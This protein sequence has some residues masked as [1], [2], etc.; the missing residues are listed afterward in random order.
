MAELNRSIPQVNDPEL[1]AAVSRLLAI[2][3]PLGRL[4]VSD[5]VVPTINLGDVVTPVIEVRQPSFAP[6]EQFG[7]NN[8]LGPAANTIL[9]DTGQL[10]AGVYDVKLI[11]ASDEDVIH[12]TWIVLHRN[13]TNTGN[14]DTLEYALALNQGF[15]TL[16]YATSFEQNER[17]RIENGAAISAARFASASVWAA[18]RG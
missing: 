14:V 9:A 16:T 10:V 6:S 18:R 4:N 7:G 8:F 5:L 11:V 2:V 13:A 1:E 17:L 15:L 3:G 12:G